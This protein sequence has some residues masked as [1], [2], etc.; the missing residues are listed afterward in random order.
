MR[1]NLLLLAVTFIGIC[2]AQTARAEDAPL[3]N[4]VVF[5]LKTKLQKVLAGPMAGLSFNIGKVCA[6]I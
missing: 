5:P 3:K 1:K 4:Y 2:V 6:T